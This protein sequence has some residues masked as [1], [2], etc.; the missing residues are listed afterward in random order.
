[1][2]RVGGHTRHRGVK[3]PRIWRRLGLGTLLALI[4]VPGLTGGCGKTGC[5][6]LDHNYARVTAV[7]AMPLAVYVLVTGRRRGKPDAS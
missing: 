1:M 3:N 6:P 2:F 4:P 5:A 7:I